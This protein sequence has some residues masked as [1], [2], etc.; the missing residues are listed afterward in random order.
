MGLMAV[1]TLSNGEVM[2]YKT[3]TFLLEVVKYPHILEDV[4]ERSPWY[5]N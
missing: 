4:D 3:L 1:A 5:M 2:L